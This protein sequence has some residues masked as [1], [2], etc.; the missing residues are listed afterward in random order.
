MSNPTTT[1]LQ[2]PAAVAN[3]IS[4]S[5][6]PGAAGNLTITGSLATA[7]VAN[8]VT[9]QRVFIASAGADSARTFTV[10]GTD[11]YGN[12]Q[13]ETVTGVATPT[14]VKTSRDYLTVTRVAVDAATAGAITVGTGAWGSSEWVVCD[15]AKECAWALG[16]AVTSPAGTTY[17]IEVTYD[18]VTKPGGAAQS[19]V[20]APQQFS[21][22]PASFVPPHA[23]PHATLNG[24]STGDNQFNYALQPVQAIRV[25]VTAGTGLCV[26]QTAQQGFV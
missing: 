7:G 22:N 18:D 9:A 15:L 6:T 4:T 24:A 20:V 5:Q 13:S 25:T 23:W 12:T 19:L 10:F 11:R 26:M 8:L 21:N 2:L 14:P 1:L 16:G 3:G 17:A